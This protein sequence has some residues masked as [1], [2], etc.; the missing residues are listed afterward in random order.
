[1]KKKVLVALST[2]FTTFTLT[3]CCMNHEWK[4]ATCTDAKICTKCEETE[5]EALGHMW[6]EA[7][8][9]T[10]KTCSVCGETEGEVLE[11]TWEDANYQQPATCQVCGATDGEP[12]EA[13]ANKEGFSCDGE[14]NTTYEYISTCRDDKNYTTTAQYEYIDFQVFEGD[15]THEMMEGYEWR[16][17][18]AELTFFADENLKKYGYS[19]YIAFGDFYFEELL[20]E[21]Y[22]DGRFTLNYCGENYSDCL[23]ETEISDSGWRS[24]DSITYVYKWYFRVP[25]G[26]DGIYVCFDNPNIPEE[27]V[28][29]VY[30][31]LK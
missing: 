26:Y 29:L 5:G 24:D 4:E 22:K 11:H 28:G 12:L 20:A 3:A 6:K 1:M 15:A 23:M 14:L 30:F 9:G 2:V 7:T 27:D 13:F 8:C 25:V 18:T 17:A 21:T 10:A 31:R 19:R 16:V